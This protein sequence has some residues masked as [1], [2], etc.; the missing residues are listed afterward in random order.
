[1]HN[2]PLTTLTRGWTAVDPDW[3]ALGAMEQEAQGMDLK[4][5]D[6]REAMKPP[7]ASLE[8]TLV[9]KEL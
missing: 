1:M 7:E 8:H 3:R 5:R 6:L 9:T 4:L 2:S